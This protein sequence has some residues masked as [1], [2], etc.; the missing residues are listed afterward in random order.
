M[1]LANSSRMARA[2]GG[3]A[4]GFDS[5]IRVSSKYASKALDRLQNRPT[6]QVDIE[7]NGVVQ[8]E[9]KRINATKVCTI[10]DSMELIPDAQLII[11]R[12]K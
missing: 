5:V 6:F 4:W 10:M 8:K 1:N 9:Y 2:L 7:V 12:N 11:R 3:I